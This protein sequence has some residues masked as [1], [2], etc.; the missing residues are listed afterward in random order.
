M[1]IFI[2]IKDI[3]NHVIFEKCWHIFCL[4][5]CSSLHVNSGSFNA[6]IG[7]SRI[8]CKDL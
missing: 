3:E 8:F 4:G 7:V 2:N 1:S 5:N 6:F